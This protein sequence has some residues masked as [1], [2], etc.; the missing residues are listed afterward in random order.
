MAVAANIDKLYE[1]SVQAD[2]QKT[3]KQLINEALTQVLIKVSGRSDVTSFTHYQNL[4]KQAEEAI[5]QFR[6]DYKTI[7]ITETD[8]PQSVANSE[9]EAKKE[10]WFWVRFDAKKINQL[11][12]TA[13]IP[14]WGKMRPETLIWFSQDIQGDRYLQSQYEQPK[15]YAIFK[16]QAEKRG[17]SLIFPFVDLQDQSNVSSA[18]IW[19]NNHEPVLLASRRY[20]AQ[21]TLT[22]RVF[23]KNNGLW[24]SQWNLLL[25]GHVQS[26]E[27]QDQQLEQVLVAGIDQLAENLARQFTQTANTTDQQ[28]TLLIQIS[29]IDGFKDF[30]KVDDYLRNLATVKAITLK[31]IEQDRAIYA[32]HYLG[33]QDSFKQ[34]IHL[35]NVFS[36]VEQNSVYNN[37][38]ADKRL[39]LEQSY[40]TVVVDDINPTSEQHGVNSTPAPMVDELSVELEY[41]LS[42]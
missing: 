29:N 11:L 33:R 32:I 22:S 31:Q 21:S 7:A 13:G 42:K 9:S 37:T 40:T 41:W 19:G 23:Q 15:I 35:G 4:L 18:D 16:Q 24:V 39:S 10:K 3:E 34:E 14:I 38:D 2:P 12:T 27:T 30:Q 25:L 5:S 8:Q 1:F 20:Q 6:Y 36:P 28:S 17:I 26:W